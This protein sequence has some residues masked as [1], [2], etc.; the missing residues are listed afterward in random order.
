M[1]FPCFSRIGTAQM[2]RGIV[3]R[4]A[5]GPGDLNAVKMAAVMLEQSPAAEQNARFAALKEANDA[6]YTAVRA[7]QRAGLPQAA[8]LR[9]L[10]LEIDMEVDAAA[11]VAVIEEGARHG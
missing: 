4:S 2:L 1:T 8:Q 10:A 6:I 5:L 11:P 7:A 9:R 3:S